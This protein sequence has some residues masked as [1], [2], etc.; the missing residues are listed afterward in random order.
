MAHVQYMDELIKEY[1]TYRGFSVTVKAFESELKSDKEKA[2]RVDKIIEQFLHYI[3]TY[4]LNSLRELWNHLDNHM[5]SK[6]ENHF[7]SGL[8]LI[9]LFF[10][11]MSNS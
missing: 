5:F 1:L 9:L 10:F 6:L 8:N 7:T 4:D 2:F 11:L 3:N